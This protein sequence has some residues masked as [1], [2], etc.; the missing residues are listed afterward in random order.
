MREEAKRVLKTPDESVLLRTIE[1]DKRFGPT[2]A[3]RKISFSIACGEIR[4][5]A[6]ENGSGKS[7]LLSQIAGIQQS[8]GGSIEMNGRPYHPKSP[9]DA[10]RAGIAI[11]V[12]E[13]GLVGDLPSGINV[14][15]GKTGRFSKWGVV[16]LKAIFDEANSVLD[17]WDLPQ[18]PFHR[19]PDDMNVESRKMVELAR[20]LAVDPQILILDEVTQALSHDNR[21]RLYELIRKFK[22]LGRSVVMISHDL[23]ELVAETDSISILRDGE[24]IATE[25]SVDLS[26]DAL[27]TKMVGRELQSRL[28]RSDEVASHGD[29]VVMSFRNVSTD[30]GITDVSFDLHKGEILCFCG[31]SDSGIHAVG[32]AAYGLGRVTAGEVTMGNVAAGEVKMGAAGAGATAE[33]API[34]ITSARQAS[35]LGIGYV[36]KDRDAEA[37]MMNASIRE[38]FT[39][40][41]L[42]ELRGGLG[43]LA[44]KRLRQMAEKARE[45]FNVKCVNVEQPM[46]GL[47]G[48]NK[49]KVNLG[50]WLLRDL[51]VLVVSCPTRGVDVGVK[52]YLYECLKQAKN[53][54]IGMI[55][56]TD[57]L[58]EAIG[59]CDSIL[60][61][62]NGR[63]AGRLARS[64]ALREEDIIEVMV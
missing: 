27:K 58:T 10:N 52:A 7:T 38:N 6:G 20:A 4:G 37:L 29:E 63:V 8:D 2:H 48:G 57:E 31:L 60:I 18:L 56:V 46:S 23:E 41:S 24:L 9:L 19:N 55:L 35:R 32:R 33:G 30:E 53:R 64:A 34:R 11:V 43:F 47:S 14:F 13:L 50:R 26:V 25:R 61:M 44:P 12:Q 49:Q 59:M 54:G 42:P 36:P 45:T 16:N 15:L 21:K 17:R 3:N 40:P 62:K 1:L 51:R 5:L 28:Y 22:A 39:L